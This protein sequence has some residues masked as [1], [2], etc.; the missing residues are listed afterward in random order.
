[1]AFEGEVE[2]LAG[3]LREADFQGQPFVFGEK[4]SNLT[5]DTQTLLIMLRTVC[6]KPDRA[7]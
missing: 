5:I 4:G 1:V 7:C 6:F 3:K 2:V